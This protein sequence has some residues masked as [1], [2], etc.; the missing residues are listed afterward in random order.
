LICGLAAALFIARTVSRPIEDLAGAAHRIGR[1]DY[2]DFKFTPSNDEIGEFAAAFANMIDAIRDREGRISHQAS[3][4]AVS[5]LPNRAVVEQTIRNAQ[6]TD[7]NL[8]GALIAVG[9]D[10]LPVAVKTLGHTVADRMI[11]WAADCLLDVAAAEPGEILLA[12]TSDTV[13]SLWV[14]AIS[15]EAA[16]VL[17]GRFLAP[18]TE[19][20]R[21]A[22]L[23]IEAMP[24]AGVALIPDHACDPTQLLQ[25]AE[26]ALQLAQDARSSVAVYDQSIDPHRPERLSLMTDMRS[27][28]AHDGEFRLYC[29][30]KLTLATGA[31][32]TAEAL[33]RWF[34]P[35]RGMI[36]PDA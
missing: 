25:R 5:G 14:P 16:R 17:A 23:A 26:V 27:G 2:R 33:I 4:D 31:V 29:Q 8:A 30:P 28:L 32:D 21:E 22:D 6:F 20:Y 13:F 1:G 12:R 3:H 36:P 19:P 11:Q 35:K 34:H 7:H 15:H 10:G 24:A 18:L 9:L